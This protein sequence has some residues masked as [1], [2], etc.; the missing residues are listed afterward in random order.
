VL[1]RTAGHGGYR[2]IHAI[3]LT[4]QDQT[5]GAMNL[6]NAEPGSLDATD[7]AI[8]QALTGVA[9]IAILN[10]RALLR[11]E[12][13]AEQLQNALNSRVVIEQAK[14]MLA[15]QGGLEMGAAFDVLRRHVRRHRQRLTEAARG[16]VDGTLTL[17]AMA[18]PDA[19]TP[20]G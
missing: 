19:A 14:G 7:R 10:Q 8:A 3:P 6:F 13:V 15:Q 12:Q 17:E 16:V 2:A 4:F 1:A 9:T 20:P 18:G 5:L 11:S